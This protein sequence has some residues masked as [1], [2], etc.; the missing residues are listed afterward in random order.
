M[1]E[2]GSSRDAVKDTPG[3]EY[4]KLCLKTLL[5]GPIAA[6][7]AG[8]G[9]EVAH[10]GD[11]GGAVHC[12]G[13]P[14][15]EVHDQPTGQQQGV[16]Q[17]EQQHPQVGAAEIHQEGEGVHDDDNNPVQ[18]FGGGGDE[19]ESRPT[20]KLIAPRKSDSP[21]W[22]KSRKRK[23]PDGLVQ[24]RISYFSHKAN[25][26]SD[27][28]YVPYGRP[29]EVKVESSR[30]IKRGVGDQAEGPSGLKRLRED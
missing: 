21:G 3:K 25:G 20:L 2:P 28:N 22:A 12:G 19:T 14:D 18:H 23:N 1:L 7:G 11:Q 9:R 26:S 6:G 8:Q 13:V 10:G 29:W 30:G 5:P 24:R 4:D 17:V 15:E 16:G 27:G